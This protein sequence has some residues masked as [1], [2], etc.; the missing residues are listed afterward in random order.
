M[1]ITDNELDKRVSYNGGV[2][3]IIRLDP[4]V[5]TAVGTKQPLRRQ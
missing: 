1:I 3:G 2:C 5:G 4:L